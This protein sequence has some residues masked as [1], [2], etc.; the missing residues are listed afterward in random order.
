[1]KDNW[2]LI[3]A[4]EQA[5]HYGE[6]LAVCF[7]LVPRFLEATQ[8]QYSFMLEGLKKVKA[9]LQKYSIPFFLL[10]GDPVQQIHDFVRTNSVSLLITDFDPLR[11]KHKWKKDLGSILAVPFYEVDARNIVPCWYA[12][13]KQEYGAYTLRPKIKRLLPE[14]LTEYPS[15]RKHPFVWKV[16]NISCD[17]Q[18]A[19]KSLRIDQTVHPVEWIKPGEDQAGEMLENFIRSRLEAYPDKKND[20]NA[21]AVSHLSPYLHFGHISSQRIALEL[22][23]S[24]VHDRARDVFL[25]ELIVRRELADNFCHYNQNYDS[26]KGFPEWARTTLGMH[27]KDP[28]EYVYSKDELEYA[29]T[30]DDLWNAAQKEMMKKGKMHGYLRMYW[31]KK[32]LEWT[33]N[34]EEAMEIAIYLNDKYELD[35]RDSNGYTGVAWAIGGVHDRPWFER[36]IFGKIRYMNYNG[37]KRKFD[38]AR[39]VNSIEAFK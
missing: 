17:W 23:K 5:I 26:V 31:A 33:T 34:P 8:R 13:A 24:T 11:I 20:P 21:Q 1:M 30:H 15:I 7:C 10:K 6:P 14:F 39:F 3:Y 35:G 9:D 16:R 2:A 19:Y 28:R 29:R 32:I 25:E 38:V 27:S 4:Q 18:G 36:G 12:S 37:C 22:Y